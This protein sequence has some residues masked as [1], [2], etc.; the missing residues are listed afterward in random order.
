MLMMLDVDKHGQ[1]EHAVLYGQE[2][3]ALNRIWSSWEAGPFDTNRDM[4]FWLDRSCREA[5][6]SVG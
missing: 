4:I 3:G 2:D 5:A 6:R 1:V